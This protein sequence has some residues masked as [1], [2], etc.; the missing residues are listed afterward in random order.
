[1]NRIEDKAFWRRSLTALPSVGV[2]L[3]PR[4]T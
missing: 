1:M 3:L 4:F 2:A